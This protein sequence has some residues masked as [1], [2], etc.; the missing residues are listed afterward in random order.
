LP[1]PT[2]E[3]AAFEPLLPLLDTDALTPDEA[4]ATREHIA[5]CAWCHAQR[6]GYDTFEAALRRHY[7]S[8]VSDGSSIT[9]DG[10]ARADGMVNEDESA[11]DD[12]SPLVLEVSP[13]ARP[14]RRAPQRRW[15]FAEI[16][17]VLVVGLLAVALLVN[18]IGLAGGNQPPL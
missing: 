14:V 10:I 13:I 1:A 18:R 11:M 7:S 9:L 15:R 16:A 4:T 12:E 6:T 8:D 5:G 2:P 17:A 3:C